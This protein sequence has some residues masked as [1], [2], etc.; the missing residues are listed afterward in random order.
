MKGDFDG[1]KETF[2]HHD[3][4][5]VRDPEVNPFREEHAQQDSPLNGTATTSQEQDLKIDSVNREQV[6]TDS[7][8]HDRS[9]VEQLDDATSDSF[10][11]ENLEQGSLKFDQSKH[12]DEDLEQS[13]RT[14]SYDQGNRHEAFQQSNNTDEMDHDPD[15]PSKGEGLMSDSHYSD[16]DAQPE[17][18]SEAEA[19]LVRESSGEQATD[20]SDFVLVDSPIKHTDPNV[21]LV[22][23]S[24]NLVDPEEVSLGFK[25][26]MVASTESGSDDSPFHHIELKTDEITM[27]ERDD[28]FGI[29][30]SDADALEDY[31]AMPNDTLYDASV[32]SNVIHAADNGV[33]LTNEVNV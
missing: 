13:N 30:S 12:T 8:V 2:Q 24:S 19:D 16:E 32:A 29:H 25:Q 1:G 33:K 14:E 28:A 26:E 5:A 20:G 7:S 27:E 9:N 4:Y 21:N 18:V 10:Q 22:D 23:S 3:T 11:R 15:S 17:S 31:N 6:Q